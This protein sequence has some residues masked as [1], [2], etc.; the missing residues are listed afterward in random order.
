[1][2][3]RYLGVSAGEKKVARDKFT[4]SP[5]E[6]VNMTLCGKTRDQGKDLIRRNT[7]DHTHGP[8]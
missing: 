7:L 5:P 4:F 6:S 2:Q 1:M 3:I 8:Q